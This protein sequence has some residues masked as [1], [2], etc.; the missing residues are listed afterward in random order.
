MKT[1][2]I[3][4]DVKE[5]LTMAN[6]HTHEYTRWLVGKAEVGVSHSAAFPRHMNIKRKGEKD[7]RCVMLCY[8]AVKVHF[9]KAVCAQARA[10]ERG[11]LVEKASKRRPLL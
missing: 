2:F 8:V 11:E 10:R 3:P 5:L 4:F 9:K 1:D 7:P 6:T